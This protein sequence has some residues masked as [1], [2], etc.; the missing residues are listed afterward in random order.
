VALEVKQLAQQLVQRL[1]SRSLQLVAQDQV[2]GVGR[3]R[4]L[5]FGLEGGCE[6]LVH[7]GSHV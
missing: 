7:A 6:G 3:Q 4:E 5:G 2:P 1:T